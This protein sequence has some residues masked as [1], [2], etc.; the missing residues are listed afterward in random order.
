MVLVVWIRSQSSISVS[1]LIIR[2]GRSPAL[3]PAEVCAIFAQRI[4]SPEFAVDLHDIAIPSQVPRKAFLS[5]FSRRRDHNSNPVFCVQ[6]TSIDENL[7]AIADVNH[8]VVHGFSQKIF[9]YS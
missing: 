2:I 7:S 8:V 9:Q 4:E 3:D 6:V 1:H 5:G